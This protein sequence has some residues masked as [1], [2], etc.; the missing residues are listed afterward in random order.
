MAKKISDLGLAAAI[1]GDELLELVQAGVNVKALAGALL[2]PGYIDGLK[3]VYG[4]GNALTVRSG[5]AFIQG[6]GRVLFSPADIAITGMTL[7]ASTWYHVYLFLN[8]SVP[9]VEVVTT[10]PA[11]AYSGTARAKTGDT[12]RRYLGSLLTDGSGNVWNFFHDGLYVR[13]LQSIGI[14]GFRPLASGTAIATTNVSLAAWIPSICQL[15]YLRL[16]NTSTDQTF[17]IDI[18]NRVG[19]NYGIFSVDKGQ[20]VYAEVPTDASQT[21]SYK[22]NGA[23]TAGGAYIDVF[24]YRLER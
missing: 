2:S 14:D 16:T 6:L 20:A 3:M 15:A 1:K 13:W 8:G 22:F 11:V 7:A 18:P 23:P 21:V 4:S 5:A 19:S 12:S 24:G 17:K 9:A 10:T